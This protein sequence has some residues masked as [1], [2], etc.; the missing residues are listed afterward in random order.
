M[1]MLPHFQAL[2]FTC[3]ILLSYFV[4]GLREFRSWSIRHGCDMAMDANYP[5][6]MEKYDGQRNSPG[7]EGKGRTNSNLQDF[8]HPC[9]VRG[10][11]S[12]C[13]ICEDILCDS[14]KNGTCFLQLQGVDGRNMSRNVP[15]VTDT[16]WAVGGS[17]RKD[18]VSVNTTHFCV[19]L[20]HILFQNDQ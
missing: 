19:S 11:A 6:A 15:T 8:R 5:F 14:N 4:H 10:G 20:T 16:A 1:L 18:Y 13:H 2:V 12:K 9:Q 3:L 7:Y 17:H